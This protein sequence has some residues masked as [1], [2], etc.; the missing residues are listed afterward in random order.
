M[1]TDKTSR[2]HLVR[3]QYQIIDC[4]QYGRK[5]KKGTARIKERLFLVNQPEQLEQAWSC[6]EQSLIQEEPAQKT[7]LAQWMDSFKDYCSI[8]R[9]YF[10]A[11]L[12]S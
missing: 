11:L 9:D 7:M 6:F 12:Q 5:K 1:E 2:K 10:Y 8:S 4:E 3:V